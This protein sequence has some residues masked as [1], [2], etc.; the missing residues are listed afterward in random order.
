MFRLN[1]WGL[2]ARGLDAGPPK[3]LLHLPGKEEPPTFHGPL[4]R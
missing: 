1:L 2:H 4:Y 3:Y